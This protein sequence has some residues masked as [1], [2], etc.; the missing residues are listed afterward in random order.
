[1]AFSYG[2][3]CPVAAASETLGERWTIMIITALVDGATRF[4]D[5]QRA[6]PRIPPSTLTQRLRTLEAVGILE[7]VKNKNG[8][9]VDYNLTKAGLEL[10]PL[11]MAIAAWGQ[12]WARDMKPDDFDPRSLA[13]SMHLRINTDVMPKRR[14]VMEFNLHGGTYDPWPF[15]IVVTDG[16][17]DVCDSHPG[18]EVDIRVSSE[19][20]RFVEAWRGFRNLRRE[21]EGGRIKLEGSRADRRAFPDWMLLSMAAPFERQLPG[22]ERSIQTRRK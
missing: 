16:A 12:R 21:V 7:K 8:P 5:L 9:G 18:F 17:V 14:I 2:T 10:E 11:I 15:W 20:R 13:W 1:M 3:Y 22:R 6:M 19:I 4:S